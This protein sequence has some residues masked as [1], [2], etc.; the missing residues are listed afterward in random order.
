MTCNLY[1]SKSTKIRC[2]M[3]CCNFREQPDNLRQADYFCYGRDSSSQNENFVIIDLCC[4]YILQIF[5]SL[6]SLLFFFFLG[7][8]PFNLKLYRSTKMVLRHNPLYLFIST[9]LHIK[10]CVS[11]LF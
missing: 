7:E 5:D 2:V 3:S 4:H 10:G 1:I 9:L 6:T 11:F 8:L